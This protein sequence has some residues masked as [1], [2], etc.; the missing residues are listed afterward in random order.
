[1]WGREGSVRR[2]NC[3]AEEIIP[4]PLEGEGREGDDALSAYRA[5]PSLI[6]PLK[7]EEITRGRR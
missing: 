3:A 4:S 1:M 2:P 5:A 7:G 6:L